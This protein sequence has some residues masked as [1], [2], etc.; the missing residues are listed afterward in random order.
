MTMQEPSTTEHSNPP[1]PEVIVAGQCCLDIIPTLP[2]SNI[3][4]MPGHTI[5]AGAL[6]FATGGAVLNTGLALHRLGIHVHIIGK[7]GTDLA[8]ELL[9]QLVAVRA[10]VLAAQLLAVPEEATSYTIILNPPH[11]DRMFIHAPGCNATFAASDIPDA[12]LSTARLLHFGYPPAMERMYRDKG[13][14]LV[15]L[16]QRAQAA[17]VTTSLDL[18]T[19]D[20]HSAAAHADWPAILAAVLPFV[21]IFMPNVE[22]LLLLLRRPLFEH[23]SVTAGHE[24]ILPHITPALLAE[25]GQT[26][27]DLGTKIVG[28]KVGS[29]GLYLRTTEAVALAAIGRAAPTST[30]AWARRELWSPCYAT[31]VRG[32]TGA[33]DATIAGFLLGLLH[34]MDPEQTLSAACA[35]GAC[36]VEATD[37][38]SNIR[39]WEQTAARIAA[40]W[41]HLPL[42]IDAPGWYWSDIHSLWIGP[43]DAC[44]H[45]SINYQI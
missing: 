22:E 44:L 15:A 31:T 23:L 26:M 21:D 41:P 34:H 37:A 11:T 14:E 39:S 5:E 32:T 6:Q 18:S 38:I 25:L 24:G 16:F 3:H 19:P 45:D 2:G 17:G 1:T 27:L 8:G 13:A 28:L 30:S 7:V 12:A 35:V 9:R 43:A 29:R 4:F 36:S 42:P 33:G 20:A 40:G 10:P